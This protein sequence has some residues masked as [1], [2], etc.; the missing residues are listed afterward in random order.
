MVR[1]F[2]HTVATAVKIFCMGDLPS[3]LWT[4]DS[5]RYFELWGGLTPTFGDDWM[6]QPGA[7]V[8]WTER[9]YPASS[10]GATTGPTRRPL[11]GSFPPARE[12]RWRWLPAEC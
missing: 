2:P 12:R 1:V 7:S 4:D 9:W 6:L 8:A 11:S 5:S 3:G 10:I